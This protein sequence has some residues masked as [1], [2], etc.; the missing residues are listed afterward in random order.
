MLDYKP[1]CRPRLVNREISKVLE[2][3]C[4]TDQLESKDAGTTTLTQLFLKLITKY[5]AHDRGYTDTYCC[6]INIFSHK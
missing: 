2:K 6:L 1:P 3:K 5:R 4:D